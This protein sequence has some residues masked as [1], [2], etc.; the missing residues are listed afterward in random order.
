MSLVAWTSKNP[1]VKSFFKN[2]LGINLIPL[3]QVSNV[4]ELSFLVVDDYEV[5]T[6]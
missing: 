3:N 1:L 2:L 5:A 4:S 6:R